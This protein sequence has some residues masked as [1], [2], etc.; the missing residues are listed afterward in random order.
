M[1]VDELRPFGRSGLPVTVAG[2]GGAPTVR[3]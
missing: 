3:R 2:Y 1:R